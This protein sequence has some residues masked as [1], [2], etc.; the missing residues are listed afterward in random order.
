MKYT[1]DIQYTLKFICQFKYF[2]CGLVLNLTN[3]IFPKKIKPR[4]TQHKQC[5]LMLCSIGIQSTFLQCYFTFS[6]ICT[7]FVHTQR[8]ICRKITLLDNRIKY[9][10]HIFYHLH[11]Q[12]F[13]NPHTHTNL[14]ELKNFTLKNQELCKI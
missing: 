13:T 9:N 10:N 12:C 11:N 2:I 7:V 14:Y 1:P 6:I 8:N 4:Y 3:I 5:V